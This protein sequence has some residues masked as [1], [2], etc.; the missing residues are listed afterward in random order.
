MSKRIYITCPVRNSVTPE[1]E[2]R[3]DAYVDELRAAGHTVHY[4]R[5]DTDQ[6]LNGP[7]ICEVHCSFLKSADENHVFWDDTS[8][9]S[10]F[11]IGM[12][13]AFGVPSYLVESFT[14]KP[15]TKSFYDLM[16]GMGEPCAPF[17]R[18][19]D[20]ASRLKGYVEDEDDSRL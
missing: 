5:K 18:D 2:A 16:V 17:E 11:D 13:W 14:P 3:M 7:A 15:N 8:K 9:G 19:V 4:P 12:A 10:H 1:Q 6:T 20:L